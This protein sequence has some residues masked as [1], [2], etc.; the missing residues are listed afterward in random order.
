[1]STQYIDTPFA[2][3]CDTDGSALESGYVF[4]GV[5]GMDPVSNPIPIYW[6]Y[7]L[8]QP[9]TNPVR[10]VNGF[11]RRSGTPSKIYTG[12]RYSILVKNKKQVTVY[13]D[14]GNIY[15][16]EDDLASSASGKGAALVTYL[17][18][19]LDAVPR[20]ER[21]KHSDTVSVKDFGA[22]PSNTASHNVSA[23]QAA[24]DELD[25]LGGGE[26][27]VPRGTYSMN[28]PINIYANT[29]I[30]GA[31]NSSIL[32]FTNT[33]DGIK[34]TWPIN[35]STA[36]NVK[37]RNMHIINT[38]VSN[39]GSGFVDIGGTYVDVE[40]VTFSGWKYGVLF[41]QTEI[42]T[43]HHCNFSIGTNGTCGLWLANGN[44]TQ[45][46]S[47]GYTNRISVGFNQFNSVPGA[48]ANI[49]DDGGGSHS[50]NHNNF[51]AGLSGIIA[52]GVSA[53]T[54][55]DNESEVHTQ[56]DIILNSLSAI[57]G[58]YVGPC[59][60]FSILNNTLISVS[61]GNV[62]IYS[63]RNGIIEGNTFGQGTS[64]VAFPGG[65]TNYS[66]G[67]IVRG[68]TKLVTG[69]G[70]TA[71]PF[72]SGFGSVIANNQINQVAMTYVTNALTAASP[73]TVTPK[74]MEFI[75][76]GT[77]LVCENDDG[78]GSEMV[79]VLTTTAST[80]T[81]NFTTNKAANWT[82]YGATPS[83]RIVGRW[84]PVLAGGTTPG[85]NTYGIQT[86]IYVRIG[87]MVFVQGVISVSSKDA[88]MAGALR[89]TGLPFVSQPDS[90][91]NTFAI[92]VPVWQNLT[93]T[94]NYTTIGAQVN[95]ST[96][97]MTLNQSG[98]N[99]GLISLGA[100]AI[101]GSTCFLELSGWYMTSDS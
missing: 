90:A 70:K 28:A 95:P 49:I 101:A 42:A 88:A 24:L 60:A 87:N 10:V 59:T 52:A 3:F 21:D 53:L 20:T 6:D 38:N 14:S 22:S 55:M 81:A 13:S 100:T 57:G 9:A 19:Y 15:S 11:V 74:S 66:T 69:E 86:G 32:S 26:L 99:N 92:A 25:S 85:T 82:I 46:A 76:P 44:Y 54:I 58:V 63:G 31:G 36:A 16:L 78:T 79:T 35:S 94:A 48:M 65:A 27:I 80:F 45:D 75:Y 33:G 12:S 84:T 8:T 18:P 17:A 83:E 23:F 40:Y 77:R 1:M 4:V 98:S 51:N 47:Q 7:E 2:H 91:N 39:A 43:V 29:T 93:L 50:F 89:V 41:D 56:G 34:S 5:E 96:N 73:S 67:V 30:S 68:N 97:F 71:A 61:F 64:A 72:V 62:N 37:I